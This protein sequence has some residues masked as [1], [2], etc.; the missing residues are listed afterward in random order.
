MGESISLDLIRLEHVD[1]AKR[2]AD[3]WV[4]AQ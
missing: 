3:K 4:R 2:A 1:G